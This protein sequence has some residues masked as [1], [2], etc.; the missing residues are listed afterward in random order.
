MHLAQGLMG[1]MPRLN[2]AASAVFSDI[3]GVL[4]KTA[5]SFYSFGPESLTP[6]TYG[7]GLI[8]NQERITN[9]YGGYAVYPDADLCGGSRMDTV[10][11]AHGTIGHGEPG[12]VVY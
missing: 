9:S 11:A 12:A 6:S 3:F 4:D 8:T 7:F 5:A 2:A 10:H 1:N